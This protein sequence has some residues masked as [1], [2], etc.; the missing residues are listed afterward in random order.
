MA[1]KKMN[2]DSELTGI[3]EMLMSLVTGLVGTVERQTDSI[4]KLLRVIN[5]TTEPDDDEDDKASPTE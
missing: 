2:H 3:I 1:N 5:D 4:D